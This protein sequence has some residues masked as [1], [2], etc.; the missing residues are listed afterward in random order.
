MVVGKCSNDLGL[1]TLIKRK[2]WYELIFLLNAKDNISVNN[3]LMNL[4]IGMGIYY[5]RYIAV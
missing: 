2:A 5:Q 3:V 4:T 1:L